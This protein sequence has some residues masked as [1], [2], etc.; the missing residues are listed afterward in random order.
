MKYFLTWRFITPLIASAFLIS[1]GGGSDGGGSVSSNKAD[2]EYI[3][4]S[5]TFDTNSQLSEL[6]LRINANQV[7]ELKLSENCGNF[8]TDLTAGENNINIPLVEGDYANC[9]VYAF[10]GESQVDEITIPAF[11][12]DNSP[13]TIS[14]DIDF[15]SYIASQQ[16]TLSVISDEAG[17]LQVMGDCGLAGVDGNL[18]S[19]GLNQ[20]Y[21][22]ADE[23]QTYSNCAFLVK[24]VAGNV[25]N[26]INVPSFTVDVTKP[27][28]NLITEV[29]ARSN[30]HPYTFEVNVSEAGSLNSNCPLSTN[31]LAQGSNV[32][33]LNAATEAAVSRCTLTIIDSAGNQNSIEFPGLIIDVVKPILTNFEVT[34]SSPDTGSLVIQATANEDYIISVTG[35]CGVGSYQQ[36]VAAFS[37]VEISRDVADGTYN[38]SNCLISIRDLAGNSLDNLEFDEVAVDS[39]PPNIALSELSGVLGTKTPSVTI[40]SNEAATIQ[41]SGDCGFSSNSLSQG[42][43]NLRLHALVDGDYSC[44][45]VAADIYG[46]KTG[47]I[48]IGSFSIDTTGPI[49]TQLEPS[50]G[51][52]NS[53][54]ASLF[55]NSNEDFTFSLSGGCSSSLSSGTS[56]ENEILL[57]DLMQGSYSCSITAFDASGNESDLTLT[58]FVILSENVTITAFSGTTGSIIKPSINSNAFLY[59]SEEGECDISNYQAC[60]NGQVDSLDADIADTTHTRLSSDNAH[61]I[62]DD[63]EQQTYEKKLSATNT[64]ELF[65]LNKLWDFSST[66]Y[67]YTEN[68]YDWV[69]IVRDPDYGNLSNFQTI[70]FKG[71]I[72]LVGGYDANR[73]EYTNNY[74][75]SANGRYWANMFSI[76]DRYNITDELTPSEHLVLITHDDKL[77]AISKTPNKNYGIETWVTENGEDWDYVGHS[78]VGDVEL[79]GG[80]SANGKLIAYMNVTNNRYFF[81]S[82][83]GANWT[84]VSDVEYEDLYVAARNVTGRPYSINGVAISGSYITDSTGVTKSRYAHP[85]SL[86]L[87]EKPTIVRHDGSL[88]SLGGE[89]NQQRTSQVWKSDNG[90]LWESAGEADFTPR[91]SAEAISFNNKLFLYGGNSPGGMDAGGSGIFQGATTVEGNSKEIWSSD[92][93]VNWAYEGLGPFEASGHHRVTELDGILYLYDGSKVWKSSNGLSWSMTSAKTFDNDNQYHGDIKA[94]NDQLYVF[95]LNNVFIS[96]DD[97]VTWSESPNTR[98][99]YYNQV[100]T[101]GGK[102]WLINSNGSICESSNGT[103]WSNCSYIPGDYGFDYESVYLEVIEDEV[104]IYSSIYGESNV[105]EMKTYFIDTVDSELREV[106]NHTLRFK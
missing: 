54:Q 79:N 60:T 15:P 57:T 53:K 46:N 35:S 27:S 39:T 28:I 92:D 99:Y 18:V 52:T 51:R 48:S 66:G 94:Y 98:G 36:T 91:Y 80:F 30:Q 72:F 71:L 75:V 101:A 83:D 9:S 86:L 14:S 69:E 22:I 102:L 4:L 3:S 38:N 90:Y 32:I 31:S 42:A 16:F 40:T 47:A 8:S 73:S 58:S 81:A 59:R 65:A 33:S 5:S 55:I 85:Q 88:Y 21:L 70:E 6:E 24:D 76:Y 87:R 95:V 11:S 1:C 78:Q 63:G 29:P 77:Y 2:I 17:S 7:L 37:P 106:K 103:N 19:E 104:F 93:G 74:W 26:T 25:S 89:I 97:G 23:E 20:F 82:S 49:L 105:D 41:A 64:P 67:S 45:F 43:N 84:Q 44:S 100:V 61:F 68:G 62:L 34:A 96:N 13:P 56:G 10:Q 12:I 50:I